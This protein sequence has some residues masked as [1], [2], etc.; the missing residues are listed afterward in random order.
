MSLFRKLGLPSKSEC[1]SKSYY[2][3]NAIIVCYT[4]KLYKGQKLCLIECQLT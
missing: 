4:T 3:V 2:K 1:K